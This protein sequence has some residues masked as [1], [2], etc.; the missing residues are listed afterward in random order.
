MILGG[1]ALGIGAAL[2]VAVQCG[3][4]DEK[5]S[6]CVTFVS[7]C[8]DPRPLRRRQHRRAAQD[9]LSGSSRRSGVT[10]GQLDNDSFGPCILLYAL[11]SLPA[12][13]LRL[14]CSR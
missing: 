13:L 5:I 3:E 14:L 7:S 12:I 9:L 1:V 2:V 10:R 11:D 6:F 4:S 8:R